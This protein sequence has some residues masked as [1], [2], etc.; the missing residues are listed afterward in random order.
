MNSLKFKYISPTMITI[1]FFSVILSFCSIALYLKSN[2]SMIYIFFN[3]PMVITFFC[4]IF[5]LPFSKLDYMCT[6]VL[7]VTR[8]KSKVALAIRRYYSAFVASIVFV[9]IQLLSLIVIVA[10]NPNIPEISVGKLVL[11]FANYMIYLNICSSIYIAFVN[12]L[13]VK[14][15]SCFSVLIFICVESALNYFEIPGVYVN[16][17]VFES[18]LS[19]KEQLYKFFVL[20][21]VLIF[22]VLFNIIRLSKHKFGLKKLNTQNCN[23]R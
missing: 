15:L 4:P 3:F 6:N 14:F 22:L 13:K 21:G 5:I 11:Y 1:Y 18:K 23:R 17:M 20:I 9:F 10:V 19:G 12:L 2:D 16:V 7:T 8:Y